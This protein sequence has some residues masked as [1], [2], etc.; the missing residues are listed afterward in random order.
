MSTLKEEMIED[1]KNMI[2]NGEA[3]SYF[4]DYS[5]EFIDGLLPI[6]YN[7]IIKEWQEMPSDYND[8]GADVLG[9]T[10]GIFNLMTA[11]LY[12]Y[13]SDIFAAALEEVKEEMK[14]AK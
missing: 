4:E 9:T 8:K 11:D 5:G 12:V 7:E 10:G 14:G 13:Y 3:L 6:Y 1:I 2:S